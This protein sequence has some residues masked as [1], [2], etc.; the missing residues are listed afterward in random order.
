MPLV[1]DVAR[2]GCHEIALESKTTFPDPFRTVSVRAIFTGPGGA[3]IVRDAYWDGENHWKIRFAPTVVG[4]WRW[5]TES[6]PADPGLHGRTG[7]LRCIPYTGPHAIYRHG[8]LKVA[9]SGRHLSHADNTPFL[10]LGDTHW[11]WE[12]EAWNHEDDMFPAMLRRRAG[13]GFNVYQV[14]FFQRW[15]GN[16]PDID[17]FRGNT[18][19]KWKALADSGFVVGATHG[20]LTTRPT[21]QTG[22]DE[23][24]MARYLCARY[25]AYPTVWLMYQEC[26]GH[27]GQWFDTAEQKRMFMDAVRQTGRAYQ[28]AD[29]YHHPRTAHSDAPL[30]TSYRGES[31]LDFTL[32]QGGHERAIDRDGYFDLW[33]EERRPLPQIEGEANYEALYEGSDPGHPAPISADSMREKAWQAM[34]CGCAGYTYGANGVWQAVAKPENSDLHKVYGRTPWT[35]GINLPGADQ[36]GIWR[37]FW[38]ALPW[39]LLQPRPECDALAVWPSD[40]P[41]T[42]RPLLSADPERNT[43]VGYFFAGA[44]VRGTLRH[45]PATAYRARWFNPRDGDFRAIG[46]IRPTGGVWQCPAPPDTADWVLVLQ[47]LRP[48]RAAKLDFAWPR[49]RKQR[50]AEAARNVAPNAEVSAS[51]TDRGHSAYDPKRAID[52]QV[53]PSQWTH[54]SSDGR[55]PLPAWLQLDWKQ[56]V[57]VSTIRLTFKRDYELRDYRLE[58]DGQLVADVTGNTEKIREHRLPAVRRIR[59][60]RVIGLAGPKS[61]PTIVRIVE[62]EAF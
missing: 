32:L 51:S 24:R 53:D 7:T 27:Y 54:W 19:R 34:L 3:R 61:Q 23:A 55:Q 39:H 43:V 57:A 18:D 6:T 40:L 56:P 15:K 47:A 48:V 2:W 4:T 30:K 46:T 31:W 8:F 28:A 42:K 45:L 25:G 44:G 37:K 14:E 35:V 49:I 20:L 38:S 12:N 1:P 59:T 62:V 36:L 5:R 21:P 11:L 58:I 10:W 26:T 29:S 13:Q 33:F 52:R 9:P 60:L 16:S 17:H 41:P 22:P 50:L